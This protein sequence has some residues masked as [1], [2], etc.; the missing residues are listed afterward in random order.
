MAQASINNNLLN[1]SIA[2]NN[3]DIN[4]HA[5]ICHF[6]EVR[7][8]EES[9]LFTPPEPFNELKSFICLRWTPVAEFYD[10]Y[11]VSAE[12]LEVIK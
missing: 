9:F 3:R 6:L 8:G 2:F 5:A 4:E 1:L 7:E 11:S 10:N 12:F